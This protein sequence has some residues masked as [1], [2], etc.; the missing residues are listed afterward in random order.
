[1]AFF[2]TMCFCLHYTSKTGSSTFKE[3]SS[4]VSPRPISAP[5][6]WTQSIPTSSLSSS[7]CLVI[8]SSSVPQPT[9]F[10]LT[11]GLYTWWSL[12]FK[13]AHPLKGPPDLSFKNSHTEHSFTFHHIQPLLP[14][15]SLCFT[16]FRIFTTN[17]NYITRF[18][19]VPLSR[20]QCKL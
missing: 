13:G 10:T 9:H 17:Q 3:L 20:L 11:P 5:I 1:M 8:S 4:N 15:P 19:F 16:L 6:I 18:F 7:S 2:L 14:I 12:C